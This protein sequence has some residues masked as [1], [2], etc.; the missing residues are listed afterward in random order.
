MKTA[1]VF[2]LLFVG[3]YSNAQSFTSADT[4]LVTEAGHFRYT[5]RINRFACDY[6]SSRICISFDTISTVRFR[7]NTVFDWADS[8]A[9]AVGVPVGFVRDVGRNESRWPNPTDLDYLIPDGDLQIIPATY[10]H[11]YKKLGLTGG[12]TR[13]NYLIVGIHY[14]KDCRE[15]GDGTWRQARYIYCRGRWKDPSKWTNLERRIMA[16]VDWSLYD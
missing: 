9:L 3:L 2:V 14:L 4:V 7:P 12:K 11:W 10:N 13:Y 5:Q 1:F 16:D 8:I 6:D 15:R